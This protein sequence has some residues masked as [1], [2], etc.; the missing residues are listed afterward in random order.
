[1]VIS[2]DNTIYNHQSNESIQF[3]FFYKGREVEKYKIEC[4][5]ICVFRKKSKISFYTNQLIFKI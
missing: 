1:M 2:L 5:S 3:K 4:D